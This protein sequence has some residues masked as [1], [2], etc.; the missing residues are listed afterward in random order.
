[1]PEL[2][3]V[4][5]ARAAI[6]RAALNRRITDV[7]DSDTYV[8][9]PHAPGEIRAALVG[10]SPDR[11]EPAGQVDLVRHLGTGRVAY[12]RCR[13]SR[14]GDAPGHERAH[15]RDRRGR[16]D[17]RGRRLAGQRQGRRAAARNPKNPAWNRFTMTFADGG[18]LRLFDPRR[19]GRVRLDVEPRPARTGRPGGHAGAAARAARP[20]PRGGQGAAPRP[21]GHR[22]R[23]QP[24]GRRDAVAGAHLPTTPGRRARAGRG[25]APAPGAAGG[26]PARSR[27]R[28][29]AHGHVH[30]AP[31]PRRSLP[32]LRRG[33]RAGDGRRP[34]D[35]LVPGGAGLTGLAAVTAS[36]AEQAPARL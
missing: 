34:H 14:A 32:A 13:G 5:S 19:L 1:M 27:A 12:R 9:R 11:R 7:D 6:E 15:R 24:A 33:G 18:Q 26:H 36:L 8:C 10:R 17:H 23:R 31:E 35:V 3:E 20:E 25:R 4:E 29:R 21:V 22:R 16:R 30:E 28:R 2:P